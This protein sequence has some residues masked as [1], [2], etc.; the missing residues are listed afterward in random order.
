MLGVFI[1]IAGAV[2]E[3]GAKSGELVRFPPHGEIIP[4]FHFTSLQ[5]HVL[6]L[7]S[8]IGDHQS[9][10][11]MASVLPRVWSNRMRCR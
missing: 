8:I 7:L 9:M 1:Y 6:V 5:M 10:D 3:C 11:Y 2:I 4:L